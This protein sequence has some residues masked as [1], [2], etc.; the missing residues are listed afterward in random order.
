MRMIRMA[1]T[2][3]ASHAAESAHPLVNDKL[4]RAWLRSALEWL[5]VYPL[6]GL[7]V[8]IKFH[9]PDFLGDGSWLTYGR[10]RPVHVIGV[11]FGAFSTPFLALVYYIVP[12]LCGRRMAAE[13]LGWVALYGWDHFLVTGSISLLMGYNLGFEADEFQL[14]IDALRWG[15]LLLIGVQAL[16]TIFRRKNFG[17]YVALWYTIAAFTWTFLYLALGYL[18]LPSSLLGSWSLALLYPF[19]GTHQYIF[20]PIPYMTQTVSIVC[21]MLLIVPVWAVIT[22][23]WGTALGRWQAILGNKDADA[24]AAKFLMLAVFFYLTGCFQGSVEALR[25]MQELTHFNDFVIAHSHATIF[26][27]F[28]V[29]MMGAMYYVWPRVTGNQLWSWR[30]ASWH[31]WLTIIGFCVMVVGLTA[32]GFIEGGMFENKVNFVDEVAA[33]KPWWVVWSFAG[34]CLVFGFLLL[35]INFYK[36]AR[37]R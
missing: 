29:A 35:V 22:N 8:S 18:L 20:S 17:L 9:N 36:T 28:V 19:Q 5:T 21:S 23:H 7:L 37:Q 26:G 34:V 3:T 16:V 25:R 15:V 30:L 27:T 12:H 4:V 11:I 33:M 14:P 6:V 2:D 24:Y 1:S 13:R 10:L 32:Q 31:L